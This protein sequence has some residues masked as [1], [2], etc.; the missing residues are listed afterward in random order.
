MTLICVQPAIIY[1]AWQLE[2]MLT[3][4]ESLGIHEKHRIQILLATNYEKERAVFEKYEPLF[5]KLE[6]RFKAVAEFFYYE[7]SR[8]SP[9]YIS[10]VRPNIL[11]QHF[12][13]LP[14]LAV[15]NTFYHDCDI[16]FTRYPEF[17]DTYDNA[18]NIAL[19]QWYVSDTRSYLDA[20]YI[21]SKGHNLLAEMCEIVGVGNP[22]FIRQR[23]EQAG[24]AQYILNG[25]DFFFWDKVER[26]ADK[27]FSEITA[28]NVAIVNKEAPGYN[29]LQIWT[30]DMWALIWNA[31]MNGFTTNIIPEMDFCWA[32]DQK[33]RWDEK[34]I[35]H[36]AGVT[37]GTKDQVFYKGDYRDK[38]AYSCPVKDGFDLNLCGWKYFQQVKAMMANSC[39]YENPLKEI[40]LAYANKIN[41]TPEQFN[42]AEKRLSVCMACEYRKKAW[43][44]YCDLCSCAIQGK[45]YVPVDARGCP[46]SRWAE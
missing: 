7:D 35:F 41:P 19:Q 6:K 5:K 13:A 28:K 16:V 10:S 31:W 12:Y 34:V 4:F 8:E 32:T 22:D 26:D 3:N 14:N 33:E 42:R 44:E 37:D 24:G 30:A 21:E 11:K 25:T 27:L 15:H 20:K 36:N 1:Y 17:L 38:L 46:D 9:K 29:P 18:N 43:L 39:L 23:D 2:V 45:I 40:A